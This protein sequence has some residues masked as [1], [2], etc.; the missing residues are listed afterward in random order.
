MSWDD[1]GNAF[2]H[3]TGPT[4]A[5]LDPDGTPNLI[6]DE[7]VGGSCIVSWSFSGPGKSLLNPTIF[8]V[9]LYAG[10]IGPGPD[11]LVGTA[12]VAGPAHTVVGLNWDFSATVPIPPGSLPANGPGV[13]GVY[14]LTAVITN[15]VG[16][17]RDVIGG[18][19]DGPVIEMRNP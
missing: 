8:T 12:N 4:L 1:S 17:V 5:I 2:L 16:G 15:A 3:G 19:V 11:K 14:R 9:Q 6:L 13:S 7:P 18:F 10:A